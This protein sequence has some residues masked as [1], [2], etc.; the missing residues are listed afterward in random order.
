MVRLAEKLI[1]LDPRDEAQR[2]GETVA[3]S[4]GGLDGKVEGW[5]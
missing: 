3:V 1:T 5:V 2:S 4:A